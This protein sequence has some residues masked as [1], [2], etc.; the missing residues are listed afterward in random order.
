MKTHRRKAAEKHEIVIVLGHRVRL[1]G[2][3]RPVGDLGPDRAD[4]ALT[5]AGTCLYE[6]GR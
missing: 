2:H 6:P 4:L 3:K 1:Q 5:D